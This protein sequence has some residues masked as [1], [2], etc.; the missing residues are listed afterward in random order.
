MY[1]PW[2]PWG[3]SPYYGRYWGRSWYDPFW[4][5]WGW[6]QPE[7][8]SYTVYSSFLSMKIMRTGGGDRVIDGRADTQTRSDDLTTLVPNLVKAMFTNFT[9]RSGE[10]VRSEERRGG[11]ECVGRCTPR[12]SPYNKK[13]NQTRP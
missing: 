12:R 9:G 10:T 13:H 1:S 7:V 6:D 5:P 4:G 2:G 3:W 11:Q 8:Y